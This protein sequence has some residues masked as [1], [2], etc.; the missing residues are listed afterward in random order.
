MLELVS[1]LGLKIMHKTLSLNY[2]SAY[3]ADRKLVKLNT[4]VGNDWMVYQGKSEDGYAH[5][6][7][8]YSL[9][10]DY[11]DEGTRV[12][13]YGFNSK[14]NLPYKKNPNDFVIGIAGGSAANYFASREGGVEYF[15][16]AIQ[17]RIPKL[18]DKNIV[19]LN[20][21][22]GGMRQP[23]QFSICQFFCEDVD[24]FINF[25]G[26]NEVVFQTDSA[27]PIE[28]PI[29]SKALFPLAEVAS[30]FRI[31]FAKSMRSSVY[32]AYDYLRMSSLLHHSQFVRFSWSLV[33]RAYYNI[34]AKIFDQWQSYHPSQKRSYYDVEQGVANWAKYA[35]KQSRYLRLIKKPHVIVI[36][37]TLALDNIKTL[38]QTEKEI[39]AQDIGKE[40][41]A[42]GYGFLLNAAH[43]L[44]KRGA[45]VVDF[46][47]VFKD[48]IETMFNDPCHLSH[49]GEE[50]LS[51]ALAEEMA[52]RI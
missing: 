9:R 37:P 2:K 29:N 44:Q 19:L 17:K 52:K 42:G 24:F 8:G 14:Y 30:T 39:V 43:D 26:Y 34:S 25:E 27:Y 35:E 22:L 41:T 50:A 18:K 48:K 32:R 36:Q 51:D 31:A 13:N 7:W 45:H 21:A 1:V 4:Q 10:Q 15:T 3:L 16:T 40:I 47:H 20:F 5:P 28:F 23:Q 11:K 6:Y 12:N 38:S 33:L 49:S 46:T